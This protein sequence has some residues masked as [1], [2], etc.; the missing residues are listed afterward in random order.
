MLACNQTVE[1]SD[2]RGIFRKHKVLYA[3]PKLDG[4]RCI[5]DESVPTSRSLNPLPNS[6]IKLWFEEKKIPN[7]FDGE[8]IIPGATFHQI[9]SKVMSRFTPPFEF[10]YY[11][12]DMFPTHPTHRKLGYLQRTQNMK[13]FYKFTPQMRMLLPEK[14]K[15]PDEARRFFK[16]QLELGYEGAILRAGDSIYKDHARATWDDGFYKLTEWQE[17]EAIVIAMKE[18]NINDNEKVR[19]ARGYA[20][21]SKAKAN[22]RGAGTLG[23]LVV[24]DVLSGVEFEIGSGWDEEEGE[25]MWKEKSTIGSQVT[26]KKKV[27]GEKDKPRSPIWKGI[28]YD[29]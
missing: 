3:T 27:Y 11:V 9:Q 7:G 6:S 19:D 14:L 15:S 5:S 1:D 18:R 24:R 21:R 13:A 22:L 10:I 26:Y 2:L 29:L 16:K 28:R 20:K 4:I 25:A 17:R 12:F 8:I 23:V